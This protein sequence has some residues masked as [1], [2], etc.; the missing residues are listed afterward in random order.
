MRKKKTKIKQ[1]NNET[2][3]QLISKNKTQRKQL[4]EYII[5]SGF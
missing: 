5:K 3:K 1:L 2:K 4:S